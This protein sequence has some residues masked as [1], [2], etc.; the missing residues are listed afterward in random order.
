[1][2]LHKCGSELTQADKDKFAVPAEGLDM[3][4]TALLDAWAVGAEDFCPVDGVFLRL[5]PGE[6]YGISFHLNNE[7]SEPGI[8][9]V[10]GFNITAVPKQQ[11]D[12]L[13]LPYEETSIAMAFSLYTGFEIPPG[14]PRTQ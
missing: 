13:Q 14:E 4:C 6:W 12:T 11:L 5:V 10:S 3:P 2:L 7:N 8:V 9:D 1:M